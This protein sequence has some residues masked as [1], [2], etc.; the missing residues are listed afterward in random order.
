[1][2]VEFCQRPDLDLETVLVNIKFKRL[3]KNEIIKPIPSL[4]E[5]FK[6]IGSV[7]TSQYLY[8]ILAYINNPKNME[9]AAN[10]NDSATAIGVLV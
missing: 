6:K 5:T 9:S 7:A 8:E 1:M 3:T 10:S 4:R 2:L